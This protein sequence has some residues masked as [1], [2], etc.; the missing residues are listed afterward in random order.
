M[1]LHNLKR[2]QERER[3]RDRENKMQTDQTRL[4]ELVIVNKEAISICRH[5]LQ[6]LQ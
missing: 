5:E 2:N 3:E 6:K 1:S 4:I